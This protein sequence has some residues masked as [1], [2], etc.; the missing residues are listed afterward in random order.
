MTKNSKEGF[1]CLVLGF[2]LG[3]IWLFGGWIIV[4]SDGKIS[5]Q[6]LMYIYTQT[7]MSCG[8]FK[9]VMNVSDSLTVVLPL[10][11]SSVF[12]SLPYS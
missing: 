6:L 11:P 4:S 5:F 8:F 2:L 12:I 3:D 10:L 1:S 7:Y 9:T